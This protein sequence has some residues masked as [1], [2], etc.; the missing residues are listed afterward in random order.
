MNIRADT[1]NE[2]KVPAVGDKFT[3]MKVEKIAAFWIV[4]LKK[5][6]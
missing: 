4:E 3:V 2:D 1:N 6:I 5:D